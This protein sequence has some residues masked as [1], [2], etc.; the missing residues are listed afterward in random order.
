MVETFIQVLPDYIEQCQTALATENWEALAHVLHTLKGM[1]GSYGYKI[2]SETAMAAEQ[3]LKAGD[4]TGV[5][6]MI[7]ELAQL[8]D[9]AQR[10]YKLKT[11]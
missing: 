9:Q 6:P 2:I 10:G 8:D 7:D 11:G 4:Y 3:K 5:A 1:G